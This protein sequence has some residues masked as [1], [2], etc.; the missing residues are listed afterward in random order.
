MSTAWS[1][2]LFVPG[3]DEARAR[4][5]LAL[6]VDAV[7]L[8]LE[9]AVAPD[10]KVAARRTVAA[11]LDASIAGQ[12]PDRV[13]RINADLC[14][15]ALDLEWVVRPATAAVMIPKAESPGVMRWIDAAIRRLESARGMRPGSIGMLPLVESARGLVNAVALASASERISAVCFGPE[16]LAVDLGCLPAVDAL[17]E[18]FGLLVRAARSVG[19]SV[20]GAP[21]SIA[22]YREIEQ[23]ADAVRTA[24]LLGAAGALAVHPSQI[25]AIRAAFEDPARSVAHAEEIVA[26]FESALARGEAVARW[27]GGMIDRPVYLQAMQRLGARGGTFRADAE[28]RMPAP[29]PGDGD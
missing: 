17:R 3:A 28:N 21:G 20:I 7:V 1:A 5:A 18:H 2:M 16:D 19:R 29:A 11:L 10:A 12:G 27:S 25:P 22:S 6:A 26:T 14:D 13:V 9:D 23:Y 4:K 24:R 8:D 15:C